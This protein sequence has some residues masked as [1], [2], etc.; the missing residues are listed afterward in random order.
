LLEKEANSA[1]HT[2]QDGIAFT[3]VHQT[4]TRKR[5]AA[6]ADAD[7]TDTLR[8]RRVI[9]KNT[10]LNQ[11]LPTK[12]H[13]RSMMPNKNGG[14]VRE[15]DDDTFDIPPI[16]F[17]EDDSIDHEDDGSDDTL[18]VLEDTYEG[19]EDV[20]VYNKRQLM[21]E[22]REYTVFANNNFVAFSKEERTAIK[23]MAAL[24]KTKASLSTYNS[25]MEWHL[26]TTKVLKSHESLGDT[27]QHITRERLFTSLKRRYNIKKEYYCYEKRLTLPSSKA[28]V[29]IICND[30]GA[31]IRSL[32]TD[33]RI[34]KKDYLFHDDDP[35]APPPPETEYIRD[36][37]TGLSYRETYKQRITNPD[38]Q[39]LLPVPMYADGC[40]SG[41]FSNLS[42]TQVKITIGILNGKA[43]DKDFFWRDIGIIPKVAENKSR[44][45]RM[46][47]E[48]RHCDGLMAHQDVLEEEGVRRN[49]GTPINK[50]EDY[51]AMIAV[52]LESYVD[53]QDGIIMDFHYNGKLYKDVEFLLFIPHIKLDNEEADKF[54]GKFGSRSGNVAHLC[55]QCEVPTHLSGRALVNYPLKTQTKI[56]ALVEAKELDKLRAMSQH[57]FQNAFYACRFGLHNDTGIHGACPM[58][59]LHTIYLGIFMRL[60]DGF[61]Q[62]I[63]PTSETAQDID[64]LAKEYGALLGR[65]SERNMPKSKFS[66]GIMGG[67]LMAKEFEGVLLLIAVILRSE[68]GRR[69][70]RSA[71]SGNFAHDYQ[72]DDWTMLVETLLGWVQ[73]LKGDNMLRKHVKAS[74]WKHRYLMY[75][76]K[77]V[78]K[79]TKGMGMKFPK[80]HLIAHLTRDIFNHGIPRWLDTGSNE[81]GHKVVKTAAQLTQKCLDTFDSQTLERLLE[82][83]LL[84]LAL[85]EMEGRPLWN[86]LAGYEHAE[87]HEPVIADPTTGGSTFKSAVDEAT[88]ENTLDIASQMR[89]SDGLYVETGFVNFV[90][91]LQNI[92][93]YSIGSI[94]VRTEHSRNGETFRAH[95]K[96]RGDVWRDWVEVDWGDEWGKLP[97]KIWGF[98]DL[99]YV[100]EEINEHY[101]GLDLKPGVYAIVESAAYYDAGP[102]LQ[103]SEMFAPIRKE[104]GKIVN[105]C[106][107]EMKFYLADV[108]AFVAPLA[109]IPDIGGLPNDYLVVKNREEWK[110]DFEAWL[111][112]PNRDSHFTMSDD[113]SSDDDYDSDPGED[114]FL[115][116]AANNLA[117]EDEKAFNEAEMGSGDESILRNAQPRRARRR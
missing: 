92:V 70:L 51:H 11:A 112:T 43:R 83:H 28:T 80:F 62:Q 95:I 65:Q 55:R 91:G 41:Q 1:Y 36:I 82:T 94:A 34:S 53:I 61:F 86:Y 44:G 72:L 48:S 78:I 104:V 97:N 47:L 113:E 59:M 81:S 90:A 10:E 8:N 75:L 15:D 79:R 18:G 26:K 66:K 16:D 32:L 63:G 77:K 37:N 52:I 2:A 56:S 74:E 5:S 22:F 106:V 105:G 7:C 19:P 73:W 35:F 27:K 33:P 111:E 115:T 68:K 67:K 29:K 40:V 57:A 38:R 85:E 114:E 116:L 46:M 109:V 3:V 93:E 9:A 96:Y 60:R 50:L 98:V 64:A 100:P 69:L 103:T 58:D 117:K 12:H 14:A 110:E 99:S 84:A 39:I 25:V 13:G 23:C 30:A 89:Y 108:E 31:M 76:Y 88:Q 17:S 4:T 21:L 45:K 20:Q 24:R 87:E 49:S 54:C 6:E 71:K 107:T 101:G 102:A 42:L